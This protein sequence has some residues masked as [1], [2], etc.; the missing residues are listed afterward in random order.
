MY[1]DVVDLR[2]FY[3]EGL[4][5]TALR[6]IRSRL[7]AMWPDL[8][9]MTVLGLGYAPP[10]LSPYREEAAR[11]IALMPEGQG[12]L[13]WPAEGLNL[14]ALTEEAELPLPDSSVD[15]I[16][17]VHGLE[18]AGEI[19][20][21]LREIWRVLADDGRLVV[22]AANRAGIWARVD[23]TPFGHGH[24]YTA[25]QLERLLRDSLFTPVERANALYMPPIDSRFLMATAPAWEKI[26]DRFFSR[27][28]GVVMVEATKQV[29]AGLPARGRRLRGR[30]I[31]V[32]N[33]T[34]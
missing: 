34:A 29:Y 12:V 24:P 8:A 6:M 23:R 18:G 9:G 27:I 28:A 7:R 33:P 16:L 2:D 25:G 21:Y 17:V 32:G 1:L 15:R 26:G 5:Q 30:L 31:P 11:V 4:G 19:R 20:R 3:R 13:R 14:T 22:V 10:Y